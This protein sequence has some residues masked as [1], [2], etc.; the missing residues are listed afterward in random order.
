[1]ST[2]CKYCNQPEDKQDHPG[3]ICETCICFVHLTCLKSQ[4]TPG[5]FSGDVFFEFTCEH[6]SIHGQEIFKRNRVFWAQIIFLALYHMSKVHKQKKNWVGTIA[7]ALSIYRET[8]FESG[9]S[10]LTE[11][12]WWKLKHNFSPAVA[13]HLIH[14]YPL[15]KPRAQARFNIANQS[16]FYRKAIELGYG[17]LLN[18]EM[19]T[20]A[21]TPTRAPSNKRK[22]EMTDYEIKP[23]HIYKDSQLEGTSLEEEAEEDAPELESLFAGREMALTPYVAQSDSSSVQ[24]FRQS[25]IY[26]SDNSLKMEQISDEDKLKKSKKQDEKPYTRRETFF[27]SQ[28][29]SVDSPWLLPVTHKPDGL[30]PLTE[31]EEIQLLKNV[32]GLIAKVK[33]VEKRTYLS[34]FRA[35]LA[36]R[37]L[38]RH[39]HLPNFDID[40]S[41]KVLGGYTTEE[42]STVLNVDR[43]LDRFQRSYLIDNLSGTIASTN[44]GTLLLSSVEAAPFR[45]SYSGV[46][47]KPY[48]RRDAKTTPLWLRLMDENNP[49]LEVP[50]RA[51]LDYS[52]IRP[53]HVAALNRLC[54]T[55]FWPGIDLT[56]SLQY[57]EFS[58]VVT[59]KKLVVGCA[60]LVPHA[61]AGEAYISFVLT[62]PEWR[63]AGIATFMLYHLLQTCTGQDV[64]LHVS[65]TNPA[66]FLY[67]KFGFKVEELVQDFYEKYYDM[68]YKGCR[69]ALFLRLLCFIFYIIKFKYSLE[70]R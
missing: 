15:L 51:T 11:P 53:H 16:H 33:D 32:E 40:R 52:Y 67:Q 48:I 41:V 2:T 27:S 30:V 18:K 14:E 70:S 35:K 25:T 21:P 37:R 43:V 17:H 20:E 4:G 12:G 47:L 3:L 1:M 64:T 69:H 19:Q 5:N 36:L 13:S 55:H 34:R 65:P 26:D 62:R 24:S 66:I 38:K 54:A 6:C 68:E 61:A 31:Y 42:K 10:Q 44:Y 49:E 46:T 28:P 56:E 45:S 7:G 60:L 59:Y 22:L 58:C 50:E 57:P 23:K 9:S 29:N 63:R 8:F 39:K